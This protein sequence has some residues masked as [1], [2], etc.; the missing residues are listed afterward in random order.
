[1]LAMARKK[2]PHVGDIWARKRGGLLV[3]IVYVG[4]GAVVYQFRESGKMRHEK[5]DAFP[6]KFEPARGI[7]Y[8][9]V[10]RKRGDT[11]RV[12]NATMMQANRRGAR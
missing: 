7:V 10:I 4:G 12:A 11:N 5:A 3:A 1:M 8:R 9:I 2:R 6:A